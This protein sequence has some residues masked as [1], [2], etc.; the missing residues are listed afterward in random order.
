WRLSTNS[1]I[2]LPSSLTMRLDRLGRYCHRLS[3]NRFPFVLAVFLC[4]A[5]FASARDYVLHSF[6]KTQLSD[7]FW[8]EGANFGD[9]NHDGKVDIVA[10]P[11]WYEGPDFQKRHE[12]YPATQSFVRKKSEGAEEKIA[13]FEG[14]L[15]VENKYSDNF[16]AF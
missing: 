7:K 5:S 4:T 10:G 1:R 16:F 13:G 11:Y 8:C 14:A 3:M 2:D 9:F 12:I 15:G 6:K